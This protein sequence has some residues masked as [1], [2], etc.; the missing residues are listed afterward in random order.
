VLKNVDATRPL[1]E[2][3]MDDAATLDRSDN[4]YYPFR[5]TSGVTPSAL[6]DSYR[7]LNVPLSLDVPS[8]VSGYPTTCP[9]L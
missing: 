1:A 7:S 2:A 5:A 6:L 4:R 3:E 9:V 8:D